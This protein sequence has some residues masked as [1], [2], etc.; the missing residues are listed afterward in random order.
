M[1]SDANDLDATDGAFDIAP[2]PRDRLPDGA[3]FDQGPLDGAVMPHASRIQHVLILAQENHSFDTYFGRYC[4]A[5]TGSNP[6]C[7]D[8]PAC[9]EAAPDR[10]PSGSTPRTL[11][12]QG[13]G[14]YDPNHSFDCELSEIHGGAM[15]RFVTGASCS[16]A[17][18]FA[19]AD[20]ALMATYHGYAHDGALA[21]RYFQPVVGSTSANDMYFAVSHFVFRDNDLKPNSVGQGCISPMS[22]ARQFTGETTVADLLL[23]RGFTFAYYHEGY[24]RMRAS[25]TCP[26]P[27]SDC[28]T[29]LWPL[30]PCN[31][32]ASDNPF[33]YY[34]QFTDD[35]AYMRDV[36]EFMTDLN[37]GYLPNL[38]FVKYATYHNEH[39]GWGTH[40]S[41]GVTLV[42]RVVRAVMASPFADSTLI[43]VT[44]D[45]GGGFF[46]H[47][48]PPATNSADN[49]PYGTR[50]PM[51]A[52]GRFARR[53]FVSH[54]V[55]EHSSVVRFIEWNFLG[56]SGQLHARDANVNSIGS[57][58]DE[59]E[60]GLAVP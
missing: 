8:G 26:S 45:E 32:D 6:T 51:I 4:T 39:P 35:L 3:P 52:L 7:H 38:A 12:D 57:L 10:E 55:M 9:C 19:I 25:S 42:D 60:V 28:R 2:R 14:D 50:I 59:N 17:R 18:N 33:Q 20:P 48:S 53:N 49:E 1:T 43:L 37:A 44:M 58:L 15:D 13:N 11:T 54:V 5:P 34:R 41:D 46:D 36:D 22:T 56:T 16:D 40:I 29:S 31:Y 27:P 24:A 23:D 21:D 30:S 47:V